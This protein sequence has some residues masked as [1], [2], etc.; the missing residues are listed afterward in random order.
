MTIYTV[1]V[2]DDTSDPVTQADHTILIR[3]G[4][5]G[6]AFVFGFAY[7]LWHRLWVAAT[8]W[9]VVTAALVVGAI[10]LHL[11]SV[12]VIAISFLMHVYLGLEGPDLRRWGLARRHYTLKDIVSAPGLSDAEALLFGR[13][14]SRPHT[15]PR[16]VERWASAAGT[17]SVI[18]MFPDGSGA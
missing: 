13:Q 15:P 7:L 14:F 9:I 11:P 4:F 1:H 16:P 8:I 17:P 10:V 2:P 3:D 18:G 6:S 5:S 12:S